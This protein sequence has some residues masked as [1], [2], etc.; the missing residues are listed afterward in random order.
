MSENPPNPYQTTQPL[1]PGDEKLWATLVHLGAIFFH[2]L[3]ALVGYFLLRDRGPFIREHTRAALNFQL[4]VLLGTRIRD[5]L[6][7][8]RLPAG[9]RTAVAGLIGDGLV[10]GSSA[11]R[12][13]L[14]LT[15][16]GRLLADAVVRRLLA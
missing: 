15:L 5:G 12:G 11:I 1:S 16:R 13:R 10:D 8:S 3:P 9:A 2:F 7:I 14:V 4:T 6:V